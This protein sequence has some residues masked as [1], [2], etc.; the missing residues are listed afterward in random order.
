MVALGHRAGLVIRG[1]GRDVDAR[2]APFAWE[3][4]E[5]GR[6]A[7]MGARVTQC[8]LSRICGACAESLGRPI[9][10]VGDADEVARGFVLTCQTFPVSDELTVDFDA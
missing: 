2:T 9:A 4:D 5:Q 1:L 3:P 6:P 7:L 8:A 10:F